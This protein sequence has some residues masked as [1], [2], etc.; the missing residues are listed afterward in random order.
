MDYQ[1]VILQDHGKHNLFQVVS[2]GAFLGA[3]GIDQG[4][5]GI[6][7]FNALGNLSSLRFRQAHT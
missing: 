4:F 3:F 1:Q 2:L 7:G 5:C 6:E